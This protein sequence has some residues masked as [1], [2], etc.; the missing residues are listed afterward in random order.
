MKLRFWAFLA[1]AGGLAFFVLF[2]VDRQMA[3][4]VDRLSDIKELPH[5]YFP[6]LNAGSGN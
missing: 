6:E 2:I 4:G 3:M 1:F 5:S